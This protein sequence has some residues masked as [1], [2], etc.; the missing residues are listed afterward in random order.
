MNVEHAFR[1]ARGKTLCGAD[2]EA[3]LEF[4]KRCGRQSKSD[5]E[6]VPAEACEEIGAGFDCFEQLK[7]IDGA[8]GAVRNAVFD[9]DDECGLG[10]TFH[11]PRGKD[12]DDAAMPAVTVDDEEACCCQISVAGEARR[13][14]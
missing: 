7:A 5:G 9:A 8:A 11:Y 1:L 6:G 13:L 12:T 14:R 4:R 2:G 10:G 3:A